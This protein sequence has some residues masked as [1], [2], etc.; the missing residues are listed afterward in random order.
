[1]KY[2]YRVLAA[3]LLF[4]AAEGVSIAQSDTTPST[5]TAL[6]LS[7]TSVNV[8]SAAQAI[9][10]SASITDDLSGVYY[11]TVTFTS[12][13]GQEQS[14]GM[15]LIG[16]TVLNGMYEGEVV[17]PLYA[18]AGTWKIGVEILDL[19]DNE[20]VY[21]SSQ[22]STL[23]FTST[24]NVTDTN[25]DTTPPTLVSASFS[26][27]SIN[28]SLLPANVT[29][30]LHITDASAGANFR[31]LV[32]F[33]VIMAP[34]NA[35]A[36]GPFQYLSQD[37]FSLASGTAQNGTWT[38]T[39]SMPVDTGGS[40]T[41]V[42]VILYDSVTN[43]ITLT[44]SQL[45]SMG[46]EPI[47]TVTSSSIDSTP[48][49]VT[50]LTIAPSTINTQTL[51][52]TVLVTVAATDDLTGVNFGLTTTALS[53]LDLYFISPSGNQEVHSLALPTLSVG[54]PTLGTWEY[55]LTWPRFSEAGTWTCFYLRITDFAGNSKTY[56]TSDFIAAGINYTVVV[57]E[58]SYSVD[59]T[60][61]SSGGTVTDQSFG[62]R[63]SL[64]FAAGEV[65]TPTTVAIDV[66]PTPIGLPA[67]K[68]FTATGTY[69]ENLVF[70]PALSTPV[71]APGVT[72]VM[73]LLTDLTPGASLTLYHED[74]VVGLT[75]AM[76]AY[77]NPVTGTVNAAGNAATF[78]NV[79]TFSPV[80]AFL[81]TGST[82]GD[83]NGDGKVNCLDVSILK[84]S[85]GLRTG[86]AGF[87]SAADINGDGVVDI[88]DLF[89]VTHQLPAG[90][91]CH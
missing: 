18:E 37:D 58:S 12:P 71:A 38:A 29:V 17:I 40:W 72:V 15:D 48:P 33:A 74:P 19:T 13:S 82:L 49:T 8:S 87:N 85:Y 42:Q 86:Q 77:G 80:L 46:I 39:K 7:T 35:G 1:M 59:G 9:V 75:A 31:S 27:T 32:N 79:V 28:T 24:I 11:C 10:I 20:A 64:T 65:S 67:P 51:P 60:V 91:V 30:S 14:A 63:A 68:G 66:L 73:P 6:A 76:N 61:T 52:A 26:P 50:G 25:P 41:I 78:Y 84:S 22:L 23:G 53:F 36:Y 62:S 44:Q 34:T 55:T 54:L 69:F 81:T 3:L 89:S 43:K 16:G 4:G 90:M 70:S 21:T 45:N 88:K 5:L 2:L 47:L 56:G 83:V 57:D